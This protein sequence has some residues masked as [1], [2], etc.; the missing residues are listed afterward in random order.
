M[1]ISQA[2]MAEL[3]DALD[4]GSSGSN[5]V[6]VRVLLTASIIHH[7]SSTKLKAISQFLLQRW[8]FY[9]I[10]NGKD[11]NKYGLDLF[12]SYTRSDRNL[13]MKLIYSYLFFPSSS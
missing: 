2:V 11:K 3:A 9:V 12:I 7:Q 4:S 6:E 13:H 10:F 8:L 1:K 5:T